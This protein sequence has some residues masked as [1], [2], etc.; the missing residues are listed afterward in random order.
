MYI[1]AHKAFVNGVPLNVTSV[2]KSHWI[3]NLVNEPQGQGYTDPGTAASNLHELAAIISQL[4][5]AYGGFTIYSNKLAINPS[6]LSL[7]FTDS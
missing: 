3:I 1:N 7:F 4:N 5:M 2:W 6:H